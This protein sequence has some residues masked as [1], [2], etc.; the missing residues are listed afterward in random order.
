M[1]VKVTY[2]CKTV[3]GVSDVPTSGVRM[4]VSIVSLLKGILKNTKNGFSLVLRSLCRVRR[5]LAV[6]CACRCPKF[7]H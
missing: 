2:H 6:L 3:N 4:T 5:S 1:Y 7:R